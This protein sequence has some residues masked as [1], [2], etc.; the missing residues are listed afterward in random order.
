MRLAQTTRQQ[1]ACTPKARG[2]TLI[3]NHGGYRHRGCFGGTGRTQLGTTI[4][5]WRV[6]Q[7]V[8]SMTSTL[9]YARSEAIKRGGWIGIQ[10]TRKPPLAAPWPKPARM[11][12]GWFVFID[13][14]NN[15][16]WKD[17]EEIL[18]T[19]NTPANVNVMHSSGGTNIMLIATE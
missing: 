7:A 18:Q 14:D 11:G 15:G 10:K 3:G 17:G 6:R 5:R 13:S 2:F 4:D 19:F 8:E 16:K 12:C 9:Y 1:A